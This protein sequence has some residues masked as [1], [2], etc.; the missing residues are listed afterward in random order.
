[1]M[2]I[3]ASGSSLRALAAALGPVAMPPMMT[4]LLPMMASLLYRFW[5]LYLHS[6]F[7]YLLK[8]GGT[9]NVQDV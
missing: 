6:S 1:M 7:R 9:Y 3:S 8:F 2:V 4:I 5:N